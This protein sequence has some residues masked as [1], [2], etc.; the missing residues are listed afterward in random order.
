MPS[1]THAKGSII[2]DSKSNCHIG[3]FWAEAIK[4]QQR[5]ICSTW[6]RGNRDITK[7]TFIRRT[8]LYGRAALITKYTLLL[9][10]QLPSI[11]LKIP[12]PFH[13]VLRW[14]K[15]Q[16]LTLPCV[17]CFYGA[18][19]CMK[20][21]CLLSINLSYV[22]LIVGQSNNLEKRKDF[23]PSTCKDWSLLALIGCCFHLLAQFLSNWIPSLFPNPLILNSITNGNQ[24]IPNWVNFFH[25]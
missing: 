14:C 16:L 22:N 17:S 19:T 15:P 20:L 7:I 3:L 12:T 18:P 2:S 8:Y 1:T 23:L 25:Y 21:N 11:S 24:I 10:C 13:S 9:S 5:K 6:L 4:I